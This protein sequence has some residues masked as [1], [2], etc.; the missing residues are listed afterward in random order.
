MKNR[1]D[2]SSD[3]CD[4]TDNKTVQQE[5]EAEEVMKVLEIK[6]EVSK[7]DRR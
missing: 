2:I 4:Y 3:E 5:S 6:V 7:K 1:S